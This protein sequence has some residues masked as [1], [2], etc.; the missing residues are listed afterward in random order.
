MRP[1]PTSPLYFLPGTTNQVW[2]VHN[3]SP[4]VCRR[5]QELQMIHQTD[6]SDNIIDG[7][8]VRV[9]PTDFLSQHQRNSQ[10]QTSR[11]SGSHR[12]GQSQKIYH[13]TEN[14]RNNNHNNNNNNNQ[15][16]RRNS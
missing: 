7:T 13:G 4:S 1:N 10:I 6:N 2:N 5:T 14:V 12:P 9:P 15:N 16:N 3:S 8:H 11:S